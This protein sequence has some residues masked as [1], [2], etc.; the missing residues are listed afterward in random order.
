[1]RNFSRLLAGSLL[2]IAIFIIFNCAGYLLVTIAG[3][4]AALFAPTTS[5]SSKS[6]STQA[7]VVAYVTPTATTE[8]APAS[9]TPATIAQSTTPPSPVPLL[10]TVTPTPYPSAPPESGDRAEPPTAT[11]IPRPD[12]T[13]SSTQSSGRATAETIDEAQ[14][15]V[16]SHR[17]YVDSLGWYHIVGEVQNNSNVP[18]EFVEVIA[19]LYDEAEKV[20]GTKLTF[21]APDVIFPGGKAAFDIIA[22]R[23]S[24]WNRITAYKLE[25][26]GDVSKSLLQE[27]LTLLNQSSY[28]KDGFLYVA[29]QV[30]NRGESPSLVKLIVTLYDAEYNVV[31]T[32]WGYADAGV[33]S[34]EEI[35]SFEIKIKHQTDPDNYHY[36]I[37]VEEEVVETN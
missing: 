37:Q 22:L 21:T 15:Q 14:L 18:M 33:V 16:L 35:S 7:E 19:R 29:G 9:S 31:N 24:Q 34:P 12:Q 4:N 17:S 25:V 6:T 23:R 2:A 8:L 13:L 3:S 1:L 28:I 32:N 20:I 10:P 27:N 30:Q 11:P 26:K 36:R 5:L